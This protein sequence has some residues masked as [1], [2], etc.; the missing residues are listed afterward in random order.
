MSVTRRRRRQGMPPD[1]ERSMLAHRQLGLDFVYKY[2]LKDGVEGDS[3]ND[4]ASDAGADDSG[5]SGSDDDTGRQ[6]ERA[7]GAENESVAE[8][9]DEDLEPEERA[10]G[11]R[12]LRRYICRYIAKRRVAHSPTE[13]YLYCI[14][15]MSH[16]LVLAFLVS[17]EY[18]CNVRRHGLLGRVCLTVLQMAARQ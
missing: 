10:A 9:S 8:T 14:I 17:G 5:S 3:G 4:T 7:D 16:L 6:G 12:L 15:K 18:D 11:G 1:V 2:K 13:L